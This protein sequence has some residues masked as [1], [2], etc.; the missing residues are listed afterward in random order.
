MVDFVFTFDL[1][2]IVREIL[3]DVE[4]EPEPSAPIDA[5]VRLDGQ[6]EVQDV[7]GIGKLELH[8]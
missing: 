1:G 5:L 2:R 3:I 6:R 4:I 7:V 8:R